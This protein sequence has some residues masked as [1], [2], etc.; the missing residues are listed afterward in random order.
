MIKEREFM[1]ILNVDVTLCTGCAKCEEW[2]PGIFKRLDENDCLLIS[3]TN[4][5]RNQHAIDM[6]RHLCP[7]E[8]LTITPAGFMT[9]EQR[10][11]IG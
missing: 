4:R 7:E 2:L 5:H 6:A 9:D 8:A 3:N 1:F 10:K 11:S